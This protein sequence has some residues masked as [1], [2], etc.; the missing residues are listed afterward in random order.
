MSPLYPL[1]RQRT[2]SDADMNDMTPLGRHNYRRCIQPGGVEVK[3]TI[4]FLV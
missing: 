3:T 4:V 2:E 1:S